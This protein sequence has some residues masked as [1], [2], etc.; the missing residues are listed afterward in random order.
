MT[1]DYK[2]SSKNLYGCAK[3]LYFL[4]KNIYIYFYGYGQAN[5]D[6]HDEVNA[7]FLLPFKIKMRISESYVPHSG[8]NTAR[9]KETKIQLLL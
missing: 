9:R 2:P 7:T 8:I 6:L 1:T 3:Q 4:K 5:T